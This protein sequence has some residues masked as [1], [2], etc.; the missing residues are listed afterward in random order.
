VQV[1]AELVDQIESH[2]RPPQ[3]NA[4]PDDDVA[5]AASPELVDLFCRVTAGDGRVG[6]LGRL[7]GP[8]EDDLAR[9][10]MMPVNGWS[11]VGKAPAMPS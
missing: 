10:F 8:G 1:Q 11:A 5:V 4:A 3:A 9:A 6:P 7:Q 2:E